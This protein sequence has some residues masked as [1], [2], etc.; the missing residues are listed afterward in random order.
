ML[1]L[2]AHFV[3]PIRD[4]VHLISAAQAEL[5]GERIVVGASELGGTGMWASLLDEA[6]EAG[7]VARYAGWA[8]ERKSMET[9]LDFLCPRNFQQNEALLD[10]I[11]DRTAVRERL[12][13]L[14]WT[15]WRIASTALTFTPA[16]L[17]IGSASIRL[18]EA[19]AYMFRLLDY[20]LFNTTTAAQMTRHGHAQELL[21]FYLLERAAHELSPQQHGR[22]LM[23]RFSDIPAH[24]TQRVLGDAHLA[25][26]CQAREV[27]TDELAHAVVDEMMDETADWYNGPLSC[28]RIDLRRSVT[29]RSRP[30]FARCAGLSARSA[31]RMSREERGGAVRRVKGRVP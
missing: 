2:R 31:C 24:F 20:I 9:A 11:L 8:E 5:S 6:E 1:Q 10:S 3:G 21:F 14:R 25:L 30:C 7:E 29:S 26:A 18:V 23:L 19:P 28:R 16:P 13:H 17:Q 12:R 27:L 22:W 15:E 4:V